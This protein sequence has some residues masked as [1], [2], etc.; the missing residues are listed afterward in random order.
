MS[1][2]IWGPLVGLPVEPLPSQPADEPL[3]STLV[4]L[5]EDETS[6]SVCETARFACEVLETLINEVLPSFVATRYRVR[7]IPRRVTQI[8]RGASVAVTLENRR[9][10]VQFPLERTAAGYGLW[11]QFA[12]REASARLR[13]YAHIID[14]GGQRL[15]ELGTLVGD[16]EWPAMQQAEEFTSAVATMLG[17]LRN[18]EHLTRG[19]AE[20]L[21]DARYYIVGG[22]SMPTS[23]LMF[24]P[25]RQRFYL[26]DEPEQRLHP[27]LQ[28]RAAVWLAELMD[29]RGA[30]CVLATH[31]LAFITVDGNTQLHQVVREEHGA[32][33]LPLDAGELGPHA[34]LARELRV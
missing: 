29:T 28:R 18:P 33:V 4:L 19:A 30:Q 17:L 25:P 2:Q 15:E 12:L 26:L 34:Q 1:P 14:Y 6:T 22:D 32:A 16:D 13:W 9:S 11:L 20:E 7:L 8:A 10:G 3:D 24:D 31:A 23:G 21:I 27:A 5:R